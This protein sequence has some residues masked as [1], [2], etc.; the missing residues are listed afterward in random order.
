MARAGDSGGPS[1]AG[2]TFGW[3]AVA[4]V[5][6]QISKWII[7]LAV[8]N[9]PRVIEV[10]GFFNFVLTYNRGVSF[11]F[12]ASNLWWKPYLLSA[13]ALAVV[14][15]L[16]VWLHLNDSRL[17]R[18]GIGLI[19]GGAVGNVIDRLIHPGVVDFLDFHAFGW[20]WP[21]FNL[22]DSAIFLGVV[23][24]LSDG[25]FAG[26]ESVKTEASGRTDDHE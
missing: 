21:A 6:D 12:L 18:I 4:L 2:V 22:A 11:G 15:G 8:M 26:D 14:A 13:L 17:R 23:L 24:L 25:L 9:P 5:A 7:L 3:A 16:L 1:W 10:T 19:A 20:H